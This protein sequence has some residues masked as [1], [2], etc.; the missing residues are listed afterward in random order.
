MKALSLHFKWTTSRGQNTYGYNICTLL[1][2]GDKK[3]KCMGGGYDMQGTSLA[4]WLQTDFQ[5]E[6]CLLFAKEIKDIEADNKCRTYQ[7]DGATIKHMS[8]YDFYGATIYQNTKNLSVR[9]SLDGASGF[10]SMARIAEAIGI[11]LQWNKESERY[12]NSSF[13][14]AIIGSNEMTKNS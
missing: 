5:T 6:L 9:V 14:T 13:Y 1:V 4:Q 12:R 11:K 2:N 7:Q 3:G 8:A 10:N